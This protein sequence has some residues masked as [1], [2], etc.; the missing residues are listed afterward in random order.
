M[1][2]K[3]RKRLLISAI[4]L[5]FTIL[6]LFWLS[7][8][9]IL[10]IFSHKLICWFL[11]FVNYSYIQ[12]GVKGFFLI[13]FIFLIAIGTKLLAFDIYKIPS[14][15]MENT[16]YTGDIILVNKLSYGPQLP[17]SPF[18]IPWIN[19]AFYFNKKARTTIAT[20]WWPY[21]RLAGMQKVKQ[22][23]VFVFTKG[24][25][26]NYFLVKRCVAIPGDEL[27]IKEGTVYVNDS[28]FTP[29]AQV[30]NKYKF[31]TANRKLLYQKAESMDIDF[32][33]ARFLKQKNYFI[34]TLSIHDKNEFKKLKLIDSVQ[35]IL[36][37]IWKENAIYPR[38][39]YKHWTLDNYGPFTI[40][41]KG[42]KIN[43]TPQNYALYGEIIKK[44][45][46]PNIKEIAGKIFIDNKPTTT[47]TTYTF[48]QNY[49]FMMGD[50]RKGS[51]DSRYWGLIPEQNIVAKVQCVLFS[52]YGG[53]FNWKRLFKSVN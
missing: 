30:K 27:E 11:Q 22:G 34:S 42:M 10:F 51:M 14:S 28:L 32:N 1:V 5:F 12:K 25:D 35:I 26:K 37:T 2:H 16:L 36:D 50:N 39:K 15:S 18:E 52:N 19:I 48:Q 29:S 20:H 33:L 6:G 41:Q 44:Y 38:S 4:I 43:L 31:T 49:Y 9:I 8:I 24:L 40:P 13:V 3:Y 47:T 17:R 23:D 21:K 53:A 45:E 46:N 7:I